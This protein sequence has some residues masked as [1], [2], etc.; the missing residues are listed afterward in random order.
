M[1]DWIAIYYIALK[2]KVD[3]LWIGQQ[4]LGFGADSRSPTQPPTTDEVSTGTD[5]PTNNYD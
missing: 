5:V 1:L 2:K 4:L 3:K